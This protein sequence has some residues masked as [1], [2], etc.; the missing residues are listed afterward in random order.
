[1]NIWI[2]SADNLIDKVKDY[3]ETQGMSPNSK[4]ENGYTPLHAAAEWGHF[5]LISYLLEKGG[6]VNITDS[7]G[8]T[9][10]HATESVEM[11][12]FLVEHGAD[13]KKKNSEGLTA[14]EK[15][16]EED[17]MELSDLITYYRELNGETVEKLPEDM[18]VSMSYAEE[19][20]GTPL[21]GEEQRKQLEEIVQREDEAEL[22]TFLQN[23]LLQAQAKSD[24]PNKRQH[25]DE[26]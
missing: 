9:P 25:L 14:L 1:M 23:A 13:P 21:L 17:P 11:A 8:D 6:D 12:K 15:A 24:S 26:Q 2:A 22:T 19:A 7:D 16:Q 4:D 10:L 3:I 20:S 18:S 5:D